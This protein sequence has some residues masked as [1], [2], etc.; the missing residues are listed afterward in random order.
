M[1]PIIQSV[2]FGSY[3]WYHMLLLVGCWHWNI[4]Q[5]WRHGKD[6]CSRTLNWLYTI[7]SSS[8]SKVLTWGYGIYIYTIVTECTPH[9]KHFCVGHSLF[10]RVH[11]IIVG[12]CVV[13]VLNVWGDSL[14]DWLSVNQ[15][16]KNGFLGSCPWLPGLLDSAGNND[17][18]FL[19]D[20][21]DDI[22]KYLQHHTPQWS[23]MTEI[24]LLMAPYF[25][26]FL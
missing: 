8:F 7:D 13:G 18:S 19:V 1:E 23:K 6:G 3:C 14:R 22:Q 11:F 21:F 25:T 16:S 2:F 15:P 26:I 20:L 12:W 9:N 24:V 10:E 4:R 5:I 17:Y